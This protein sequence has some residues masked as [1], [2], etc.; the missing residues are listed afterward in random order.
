MEFHR[1]WQ[2]RP[3]QG[4]RAVKRAYF[5]RDTR[6]PC[7]SGDL[8]ASQPECGSPFRVRMG[9][10]QHCVRE[11]G[12]LMT[13][14]PVKVR[15]HLGDLSFQDRNRCLGLTAHPIAAGRLLFQRPKVIVP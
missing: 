12:D 5:L 14:V 15:R 4:Q 7:I 3:A 11:L 1:A 8:H 6:R 9:G 2:V 13:L 10:S